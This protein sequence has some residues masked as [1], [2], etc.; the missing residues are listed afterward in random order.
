MILDSDM[1]M[2]D[3]VSGPFSCIIRLNTKTEPQDAFEAFFRHEI[4]G[5][6]HNLKLLFCFLRQ[7]E[8][9]SFFLFHDL[10]R[11]NTKEAGRIYTVLEMCRFLT[12]GDEKQE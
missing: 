3:A 10:Y 5:I 7:M 2:K 4:H 8:G 1:E 11:A 6:P 9:N 12:R